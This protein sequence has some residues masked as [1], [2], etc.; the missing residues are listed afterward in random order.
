METLFTKPLSEWQIILGKYFGALVLV[1]IAII[2]TIVYY[3]TIYQLG[4]PVGN[5]DRGEVVGSYIGLSFLAAIFVA[6]SLYASVLSSNQVVAFLI[7]SLLCFT[8]Y[9]GFQFISAIP[10]FFG[11]IDDILQKVGIEYH[12]RSISKGAIDTR[13]V[14]Y[15]L[16]AI[17][18]FLLLTHHY[19]RENRNK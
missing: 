17:F 19:L 3:Y 18:I 8:V 13:D 7:G 2:P 12:Y 4:A 10:V 5:I 16:S 14:V 1:F 9:W 11:G 6:I 15:F